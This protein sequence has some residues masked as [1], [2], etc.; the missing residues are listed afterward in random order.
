MRINN[1][2]VLGRFGPKSSVSC[3]E[4]GKTFILETRMPQKGTCLS[5]IDTVCIPSKRQNLYPENKNVRFWDYKH[6]DIIL[7]HPLKTA[8]PLSR[9]QESMF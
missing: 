9:K 3:P 2:A 8:K 1:Y 7:L 4:N 5:P 6:N